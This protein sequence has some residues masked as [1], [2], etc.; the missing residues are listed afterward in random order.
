VAR[1]T[2]HNAD[3][4]ARLDVRIGDT[5]WVAKGGDVI[6][7][8][9]AVDS[10]ARRAGADPFRMPESC[11]ACRTP[12]TREP[13]EVVIRCPN[14]DCPAVQRQRLRHFVS[15]AAMD[16][17]G[18]GRNLID[19]LLRAGM[20]NDPAS[21][22]DLDLR[23]L[24]ELPGWGEK[25]AAKLKQELE[26]AKVRPFWRLLVGLGIRHVGE[27]AAK[28]LAQQF[29]SLAALQRATADRLQ[30]VAGIGPTIAASVAAFFADSD[31]LLLVERLRERG[32]DPRE[33]ATAGAVGA[34]AGSTFVLTGTLS[35]PREQVS[36]LLEAAG[37]KVADSVSKRTTWVV[38]GSDAGSKLARARAL[39]VTVLDEDGLNSLLAEKGVAW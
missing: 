27:R 19:Q 37:A 10:A 34:L 3:E 28:L 12:V 7:K 14:R 29:G 31:Q 25:S 16:I 36:S 20:A 32:V 11:P 8:V 2:L 24:A 15:R 22:W 39:G 17:E 33:V 4:V 21:L 18:L 1:A 38:A 26:A 6:P 9:V 35:R 23:R 13:G 5:V 30:E